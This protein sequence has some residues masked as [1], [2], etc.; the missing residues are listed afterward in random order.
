M[1]VTE[2]SCAS[3]KESILKSI[4]EFAKNGKKQVSALDIS[5]HLRIT[6]SIVN[7][8]LYSLLADGKIQRHEEVPP[9][10]QCSQT[11]CEQ[12]FTN[13]EDVHGQNLYVI[14]DLGNQHDCLQ[15]LIPFAQNNIVTVRAYADK[16]YTGFGVNPSISEKNVIIVQTQSPHRNAA[17]TH[18]I[19]DICEIATQADIS[20]HFV[21]ATKDLGFQAL[22]DKVEACPQKHC[23]EFVQGWNE[24]RYYVE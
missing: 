14:I 2:H 21:V 15:R 12:D 22:K 13:S 11:A 5:R 16:G 20:L 18:L 8:S 9:L 17:D 6:K 1:E 24:L 19:W 4:R 3:L 10:W 23:L 7:K